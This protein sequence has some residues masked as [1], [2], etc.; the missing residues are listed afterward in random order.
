[1][2]AGTVVTCEFPGVIQT[3]RRPAVIVSSDIYHNERPD[4]IL[5]ILTTN[6]SVAKSSTDYILQDWSAANLKKPSA[7]RIFL[8]TLPKNKITKIGELSTRDWL[9]VQKCLQISIEF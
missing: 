1:M 5:A 7:A 4:V 6:I 2:R 9:K 8:F 3:K